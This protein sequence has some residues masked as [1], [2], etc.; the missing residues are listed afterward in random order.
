MMVGR[1]P[2]QMMDGRGQMMDGRGRGRGR[3]RGYLGRGR[4]RSDFGRGG[5]G[6]NDSDFGRGGGRG[7]SDNNFGGRGGGGRGFNDNDFGRGGGRG[8]MD[9]NRQ[10]FPPLDGPDMHLS[11]HQSQDQGWQRRGSFNDINAMPPPVP[12]ASQEAGMPP[13]QHLAMEPPAH[14]SSDQAIVP[15]VEP[16]M[17]FKQESV[18][19][20][21]TTSEKVAP[22]AIQVKAVPERP[23]TPPIPVG[24]PSGAMSALV[25]WADLEQQMEYAYA[26]HMQVI[27]RHNIL[28]AQTTVLEELP[29]GWDAFKDDFEML[30]AADRASK[31]DTPSA[32]E[33]MQNVATLESSG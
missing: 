4:G 19:P 10:Q 20:D 1:E 21:K 23:P 18:V 22:P 9:R 12:S 13:Y 7:F 31:P 2:S 3:G 28:E 29:V 25:R 32:N 14:R 5:G 30:L 24:K 27:K 6:F 17:T 8:F 33:I 11:Q 26:K 16:S 15:K